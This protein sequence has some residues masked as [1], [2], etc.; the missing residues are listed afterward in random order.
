MRSGVQP[1]ADQQL[2]WACQ[3][4]V[5]AQVAV[6]V[7]VAPA[8]DQEGRAADRAVVLA[9]RAVA[10]LLVLGLVGQPAQQPGLVLEVLLPDR[11]PAL[12]GQ[13]RP[14]RQE[15]AADHRQPV[16]AD[17]VEHLQ[18]AA[19]VVAVVGVAA[20]GEV[21]GTDRRQRRRAQH[22]D[23]ERVE[24]AVRGAEHADLAVAPGLLGQPGDRRRAVELL[25]PA[26]L[27]EG[28][29]LR[30]AGAAHVDARDDEAPF[31]QV[32]VAPVALPA[33]VVLAVWQ[34]LEQG[35]ARPA[36]LARPVGHEQIRRQRHPVRH[37]DAPAAHPAD[38]V[39]GRRLS[40]LR[41]HGAPSCT[42]SRSWARRDRRARRSLPAAC[43]APSPS[44]GCGC[45]PCRSSRRRS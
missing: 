5:G 27:V 3:R 41:R 37:G 31:G 11:L 15:V 10:P 45:R 17:V 33:R 21:H 8:A 9:Q 20:V 44:R 2:L 19:L 6:R 43:R 36:G 30:V 24:A 13:V 35:R 4:L 29:A 18:G 14:R 25:L 42:R 1:G 32:A 16:G 26:V 23:L 28:R 40:A 12:A 7:A 39:P 22:R 38:V 34:V